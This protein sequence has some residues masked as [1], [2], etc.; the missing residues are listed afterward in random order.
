MTGEWGE[1]LADGLRKDDIA[2]SLGSGKS[3]GAGAIQLR[4]A[5]AFNAGPDDLRDICAGEDGKDEDARDINVLHVEGGADEVVEEEYLD[6]ER[7]ATDGL[8]INAGEISEREE[9]GSGGEG[10]RGSR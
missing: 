5:D 8:D 1:Y 3:D 10:R 6:E 2:I 4:L 9:R 7:G